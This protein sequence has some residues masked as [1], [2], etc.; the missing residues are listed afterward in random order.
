MYKSCPSAVTR[1]FMINSYLSLIVF[2][3][4]ALPPV[5]NFH[6][7]FPLCTHEYPSSDYTKSSL[8]VLFEAFFLSASILRA[9]FLYRFTH[10]SIRYFFKASPNFTNYEN[11]LPD[12]IFS[13]SKMAQSTGYSALMASE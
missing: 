2:W 10:C 11:D 1:T 3:L 6:L 5:I 7:Y 12:C 4:F 9:S 8:N 13:V